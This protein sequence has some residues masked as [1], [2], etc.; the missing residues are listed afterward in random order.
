MIMF[1]LFDDLFSSI[2][3]LSWIQI[4]PA[5]GRIEAH[6][7]QWAATRGF[8]FA[9]ADSGN[10]QY[11]MSMVVMRTIS[12]NR[13]VE[14]FATKSLDQFTVV[15]S[16]VFAAFDKNSNSPYVQ[17][18]LWRA[19][20]IVNAIRGRITL[21]DLIDLKRRGERK[22]H[23]EHLRLLAGPK[24]LST[25]FRYFSITDTFWQRRATCASWCGTF[26]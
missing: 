4:I 18:D 23:N 10:S 21:V 11:R 16:F 1:V 20:M 3:Q 15:R 14:T 2:A 9:F 17:L 24:H 5:C 8:V 25:V 12:D 22:T 6:L 13:L 26:H 7:N 19:A